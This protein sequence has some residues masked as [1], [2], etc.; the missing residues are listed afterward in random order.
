MKKPSQ[1]IAVDRDRWRERERERDRDRDRDRERGES[2]ECV[3]SARLDDDDDDNILYCA[4]VFGRI[5]FGLV[6][7]FNGI[8]NFVGYLMPKLFS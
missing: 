7:L 2:R 8:S 1:N 6:S 5:R 3:I 4:K